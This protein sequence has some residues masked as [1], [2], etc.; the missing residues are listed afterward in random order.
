MSRH[1]GVGFVSGKPNP[2]AVQQCNSGLK[3]AFSG[4]NKRLPKM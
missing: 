3:I 1:F 4:K 2:I